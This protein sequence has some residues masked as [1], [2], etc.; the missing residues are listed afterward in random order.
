MEQLDTDVLSLPHALLLLVQRGGLLQEGYSS[1]PCASPMGTQVPDALGRYFWGYLMLMQPG[2]RSVLEGRLKADISS[3][4]TGCSH[5]IGQTRKLS[6]L[7]GIKG[8][9]TIHLPLLEERNGWQLKLQNT[10]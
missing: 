3:K 1:L 9:L 4:E 7:G 8:R 5:S 10:L 6:L 2:S